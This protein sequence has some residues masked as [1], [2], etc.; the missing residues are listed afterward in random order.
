M[1]A[2]NTVKFDLKS[3]L[4]GLSL[5]LASSSLLA[6]N[7]MEYQT[8]LENTKNSEPGNLIV[9]K[10][11]QMIAARPYVASTR[12]LKNKFSDGLRFVRSPGMGDKEFNNFARNMTIL[13]EEAAYRSSTVRKTLIELS[14]GAGEIDFGKFVFGDKTVLAVVPGQ[15]FPVRKTGS[16]AIAGLNEKYAGDRHKIGYRSGIGSGAIPGEQAPARLTVSQHYLENFVRARE[17]LIGIAKDFNVS[18]EGLYKIEKA[19]FAHLPFNVEKL[20]HDFHEGLRIFTHEL[21]HVAANFKGVA[22]N[23]LLASKGNKELLAFFNYLEETETKGTMPV[24]NRTLT[25]IGGVEEM[26]KQGGLGHGPFGMKQRREYA[27][28][29]KSKLLDYITGK[30]NID[31][32]K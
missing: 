31:R 13:M 1:L 11:V 25:E 26:R 5:I 6:D 21:S 22:F 7:S 4:L 18:F 14:H 16:A 23:S 20:F 15:A 19:G 3:W 30:I 24:E 9:V 8:A 10:R 17:S 27:K 28:M 32:L 12:R 29:I 2:A